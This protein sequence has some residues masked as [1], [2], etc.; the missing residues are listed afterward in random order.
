MK[1]KLLMLKDLLGLEKT[2]FTNIS[3]LC[4]KMFILM[5]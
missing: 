2:R 4:Q 3:Q 1:E 5:F